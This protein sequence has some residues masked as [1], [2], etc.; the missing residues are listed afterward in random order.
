VKPLFTAENGWEILELFVTGDV[1]EGREGEM[2][3]NGVVRKTI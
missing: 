1:R 3:V 2:W